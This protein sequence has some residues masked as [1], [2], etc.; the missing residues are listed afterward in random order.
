MIAQIEHG[1]S[2]RETANLGC[3][4]ATVHRRVYAGGDW[5]TEHV[6]TGRGWNEEDLTPALTWPA[7]LR[8]RRVVA[9]PGMW[10][11]SWSFSGPDGRATLEWVVIDGRPAIRWRRVGTH[12]VFRDP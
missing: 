3:S 5:G 7:S 8:V 12:A 6:G 2:L 11:M 10:E 9:A 4:V 1:R